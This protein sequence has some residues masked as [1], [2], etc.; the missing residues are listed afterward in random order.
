[1]IACWAESAVFEQLNHHLEIHSTTHLEIQIELPRLRSGVREGPNLHD[2]T[3]AWRSQ[4]RKP[5]SATA[6]PWS[7]ALQRE[8]LK[9]QSVRLFPTDG[10]LVNFFVRIFP[11][12]RWEIIIQLIADHLYIV[13]FGD[14]RWF[15]WI[16]D[17]LWWFLRPKG[18]FVQMVVKNGR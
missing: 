12:Q 6:I 17:F 8:H 5:I 13:G 3:V 2:I 11:M 14:S 1:M 4:Q 10:S 7:P 18:M 9:S 16:D 15:P